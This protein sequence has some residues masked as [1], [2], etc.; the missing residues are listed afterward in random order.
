MSMDRRLLPANLNAA[1]PRVSRRAMAALGLAAL[2][3]PSIATPA[4][5]SRPITLVVPYTAGSGPDIL[6]RSLGPYLSSRLGQPVVVDNRAGASG[7]IGTG[8]VAR[9][10]NDGYTL[11]VT[12][13]T[14][15]MTPSLYR[16]P[17]SPTKDLTPIG[18]VAT[19]TL[20]LVVNPTLGIN[21]VAELVNRAKRQPGRL[22][23]ASPGVGTPQ[24]ISMELFKQASGTS[25]L[26]IPY[27]GMSGALTDVMGGQAQVAMISLHVAMPHVVAGKLKLLA[28]ADAKRSAVA[29]NVPTFVE[30][31]Y[32]D[33]SRP[34]WIGFFAPAGTPAS[35]VD[36]VNSVLQEA[37]GQKDIQQSLMH[38]GLTIA[39]SSPAEL[40]RLLQDDL[41]RWERV[42]R[43]AGITAD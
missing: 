36:R 12:A 8:F 33:L 27:K 41:P 42:V 9:A 4:Y 11:L 13:D 7:T 21:T 6:A 35:V 2:T 29:P 43:K 18:R 19:G 5:P 20:A 37:L 22:A 16:P 34:S 15:A 39:P 3:L 30:C 17:Y 32:P 40:G 10:Q 38:Q 28:I 14:L 24:H 25:M 23:Y 1:A 26:H 31:G